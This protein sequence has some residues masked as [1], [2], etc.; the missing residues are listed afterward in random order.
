MNLRKKLPKYHKIY[1]E[2]YKNPFIHHKSIAERTKIS[3]SGVSRHIKEMYESLILKGPV[4]SLNPAHNY[5]QYA[6]FLQFEDP[7]STYQR[8][9]GF[10]HVISKRLHSG[11]WNIS[12][13]CD[14]LLDFSA[15]NGFEQYVALGVKGVTLYSQVTSLDWD[16]SMKR[17]EALL[18]SP[19]K[20]SFL[21]KEV[22]LL[23]WNEK[24]WVLYHKFQP[25]IR[26]K[27]MPILR[28]CKT[29]FEHYQKW[30]SNLP[31]V[32]VIQPGFYPH[33]VDNYLEIDFLCESEYQ[34]QVADILGLLPSTSVFF[35]VREYLLARLFVTSTK[36][37]AD[38]HLF[39]HHLE[40]NGFLTEFYHANVLKGDKNG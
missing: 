36:Q 15:L 20:K 38:L 26:A 24:E 37:V 5:H 11:K 17:M 10:P 6:V 40:K 19:Q 7:L 27:A 29:R 31:E 21:Y 16:L 28:N 12:L 8:F 13:I 22:P 39:M 30:I 25:N 23:P 2:L 3:R 1:H 32:A 34:K 9:E 33:G 35:S 4:I 14:R 18:S